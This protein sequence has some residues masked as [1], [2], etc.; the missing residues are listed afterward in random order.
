MCLW[1]LVTH[2]HDGGVQQTSRLVARELRLG[3]VASGR[4]VVLNA[5]RLCP[6]GRLIEPPPEA[7]P[8]ST[9]TGFAQ[10]FSLLCLQWPTASS[11]A[12]P[13]SCFPVL[14]FA[15]FLPLHVGT[16]TLSPIT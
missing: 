4:Y 3:T 12:P 13:R 7:T 9:Q 6:I 14:I 16:K 1:R 10:G 8:Q 15:V 11:M 5:H 2:S